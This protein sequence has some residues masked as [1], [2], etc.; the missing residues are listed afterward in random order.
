MRAAKIGLGFL[1]LLILFSS[2]LR[3]V[4]V[5]GPQA[6][7]RKGPGLEHL[8]NL[9][10]PM[11]TPLERISAAGGWLYIKDVDNSKHWV[12]EDLVTSQFKCAVIKSSFANLRTGPGSSYSK[13]GVGIG[14]KY[15][16][17]KFLGE[18]SGWVKVQDIDGDAMWI[19]REF[20][21]IQ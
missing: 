14:E 10:A 19:K 7:L 16:S 6:T 17:F 5:N 12:R 20:V 3:A 1:T 8:A 4:C 15:L 13:A 21:W 11:F 18:K 2:V 9:E